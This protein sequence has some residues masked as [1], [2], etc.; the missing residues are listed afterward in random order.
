MTLPPLMLEPK[1]SDSWVYDWVVVGT[2]QDL[3]LQNLPDDGPYSL[4]KDLL[5]LL[6]L[7][8]GFGG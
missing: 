2:L 4:D 7:R 8:N 3:F 5:L 1:N 6:L